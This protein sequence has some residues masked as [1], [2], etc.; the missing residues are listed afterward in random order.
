MTKEKTTETLALIDGHALV[1]RAYHAL[2]P[3]TTGR[4]ELVNA[5][6]G[7]VSILLKVLKD[8]RP[9]YIAAAFDLAAPTF[10][11][12]EFAEY[13]ATRV[14]APDEL[15]AQIKRVKEALTAFNIPVFEQEGFEADDIIGTLAEQASKKVKVLIVTGDLDTLQ[16]VSERVNVFT[17]KKGLQDTV[18]YDAAAVKKRFG[19][20]SPEQM[21]DY[22]GLKGDPSDNIPG[23]PGVGE[24]TAVELLRQYGS[25]EN[26][27]QKAAKAAV[28]DEQSAKNK[29]K[30]L[31]KNS[32]L[33]DKLREFKEQAFF[34]KYLATI[35]RD[36][37]VAIDLAAAKT[38]DFDRQKVRALFKELGFYSLIKRLPDELV[39]DAPEKRTVK[40]TASLF[41]GGAAAPIAVDEERE[42]QEKIEQAR[43]QSVLSPEIYEIEK[44]LAPVILTMQKNGIKIDLPYL[45]K[46]SV[47]F[48]EKLNKLEEAAYQ[49]AGAQF[50]LNS[51]QQ[52]S[53]ILFNKLNLQ[54]KG[55]KKTPGKVVSTAAAEL[56]KLR[57]RHPLVG[58]ILEYRELAKLKNTYIDALPLLVA[59]DGRLHTTFD[60]LGTTTG[61]LSSKNPN[62][63]NIPIKTE[64]GRQIRRA[65]IAEDGHK[66]LSVDYSQIELRVVAHLAE[67]KEMIAAFKSG[68]DIHT[69][70]AAEVLNINLEQVDVEARRLAKTLNFGAL[71]GMGSR[72]FAET[73]GVEI[74]RAK[75]FIK[76]YFEK[77][78][79]VA[80]YLE[81]S[82][83][84]AAEDGFVQTLFGRKRFIPEI[85]SLAWNLR[86][87]A[88]RMAINMPVQGTAADLLKM[89]MVAAARESW[90]AVNAR[91]LLQVHDELVFEVAEDKV[92]VVAK[93]VKEIMENIYRL[94]VPLAAECKAG[95]NWGEMKK[96]L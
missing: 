46:I 65:F 94:V 80:R 45:K 4:G 54:V 78:S 32:K 23:V 87:A 31:G 90:L 92:L 51:P 91:L 29:K 53:D 52:L 59:L 76:R 34:S 22:K 28:N 43:E 60:Q 26:L 40:A 42:I 88:E 93:K 55:L 25:L 79:G 39:E 12:Q 63:Q 82:R 44:A 19:G 36:A 17:L 24:K 83:R 96:I 41:D 70:T 75:E 3:L 57:D 85:N 50:N 86:Q 38:R 71:Y 2:P 13:K 15:Y 67:D 16:L 48:G 56:L 35:R 72:S 66:L 73:A 89:A 61:R 18:V 69:A 74:G 7:F 11:H 84:Q 68:Q 58:L 27:Y 10:R 1:H 62:L 37:P 20:L 8:W 30:K 21:N 33:F 49:L 5:V 9:E 64:A 14:K 47:D 81:K 77:F 95:D 6:F